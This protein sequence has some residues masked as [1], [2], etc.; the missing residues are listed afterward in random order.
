[1]V[2]GQ[3]R[4]CKDLQ[5]TFSSV[6]SAVSAEDLPSS[7]FRKVAAI[8]IS[9]FRRRRSSSFRVSV[10]KISFMPK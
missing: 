10:S 9:S 7:P 5:L 1:M 3:E 2:V 4:K 8:R 6:S